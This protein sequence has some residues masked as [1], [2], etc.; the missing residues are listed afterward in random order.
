MM[1]TFMLAPWRALFRG[2]PVAVLAAV[3]GVVV[4]LLVVSNARGQESRVPNH[5]VAW[6]VEDKYP[7]WIG[8]WIDGSYAGSLQPY[9]GKWWYQGASSNNDLIEFMDRNNPPGRRGER[10]QI[11][12][13]IGAKPKAGVR[14]DD[15][16]I[17]DRRDEKPRIPPDGVIADKIAP[18]G[19]S[20]YSIGGLS[21]NRADALR[22]IETASGIP[23]DRAKTRL[24]VIG[25]EVGRKK[26]IDDLARD[27]LFTF[28][29]DKLVV[30][31]YPPNHDAIAADRGFVQPLGDNPVIQA[32]GPDGTVYWRQETYTGAP[33]LAKALRDKVPGYDPLKDPHPPDK[34][35]TPT[36]GEEPPVGLIG[37]WLSSLGCPLVTLLM[38]GGAA[39]AMWWRKRKGTA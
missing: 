13:K 37:A 9:E 17:G 16:V 36:A 1:R 3:L 29:R 2:D 20:H 26:V 15:G 25:T 30:L 11:G 12:E 5:R 35:K 31:Q 21:A 10:G 33:E 28:W 6:K 27:P 18:D 8:L 22:A 38:G 23:D 19:Q 39:G 32:Q 4:G 7:G 24:I 34:A 14:E